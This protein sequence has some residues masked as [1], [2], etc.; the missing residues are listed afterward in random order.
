MANDKFEIWQNNII[1]KNLSVGVLV[2]FLG[3][4]TTL[5]ALFFPPFSSA[6][7]AAVPELD[8]DGAELQFSEFWMSLQSKQ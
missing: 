6:A 3:V 4:A 7:A 8:V 1:Q 2:L 5:V